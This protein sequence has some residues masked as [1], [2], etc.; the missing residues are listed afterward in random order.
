M[1]QPLAL[2]V[3]L[4]FVSGHAGCSSVV[5]SIR[6]EYASGMF[7]AFISQSYGKSTVAFY[8][9]DVAREKA[10]KAK[11]SPIKINAIENLFVWY[12]TY[13][14]SL[15][16]Y[17]KY[18]TGNDR[19]IGEYSQG[20]VYNSSPVSTYRSEWG[21]SPEQARLMREFIY[22][23]GEVISGVFCVT[24]GSPVFG[25]IGV[26]AGFDGVHRIYSS[27]N[28]IWALH[29]EE[30]LALQNWEENSFKPAVK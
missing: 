22:G 20:L 26:T 14:S 6:S 3:I 25:A 1:I 11:E 23:I 8:Q 13:A 21:N 17:Y 16:L 7:D 5:E 4:F 15:G 24:V 27:L 2:L 28:S 29:H 18:P 10:K 30:L 9:F 19:I 12:R